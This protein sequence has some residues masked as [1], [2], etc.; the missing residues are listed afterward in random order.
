MKRSERAAYLRERGH[1]IYE[2]S[3]IMGIAET[4]VK[5][6]IQ[7]AAKPGSNVKSDSVRAI[8]NTMPAEIRDWVKEIT[9]EGAT[10]AQT[11]CAII[12]DAYHD[13]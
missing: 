1:S 11:I 8:L 9:P 12:I 3:E 2:I 13:R 6:H 4:T 10:F 7:R 5:R